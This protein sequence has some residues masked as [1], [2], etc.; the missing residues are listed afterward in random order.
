MRVC[1]LSRAPSSENDGNAADVL[2]MR[3]RK[4]CE[5]WGTHR[6]ELVDHVLELHQAEPLSGTGDDPRDQTTW[7][8][9]HVSPQTRQIQS[10]AWARHKKALGTVSVDFSHRQS[11]LHDKGACE[12]WLDVFHMH[13]ELARTRLHP[14]LPVLVCWIKRTFPGTFKGKDRRT[15]F[16]RLFFVDLSLLLYLSH[17]PDLQKRKREGNSLGPA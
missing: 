11:L 5:G 12:V 14:P 10:N 3:R 8:S 13:I 9:I 15:T 17:K 1:V 4:R 6:T 2:A 16:S 7:R